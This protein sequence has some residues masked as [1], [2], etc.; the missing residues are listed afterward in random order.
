MKSGIN[1]IL[2]TELV[3]LEYDNTIATE[4][5]CDTKTYLHFVFQRQNKIYKNKE[6]N[7]QRW[8]KII[9][10]NTKSCFGY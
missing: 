5:T 1:M 8:G 2:K 10:Q 9:P 6:N 7:L 4:G 3:S